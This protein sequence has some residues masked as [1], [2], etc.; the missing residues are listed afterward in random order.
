MRYYGRGWRSLGEMVGFAVV[1]IRYQVCFY[2]MRGRWDGN[3]T[4]R[5]KSLVFK[6]GKIVELKSVF[7]MVKV[8]SIACFLLEAASSE[9]LFMVETRLA[10]S[11][12]QCLNSSKRRSGSVGDL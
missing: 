1:N 9:Y 8:G 12:P 4:L 3:T 5:I 7:V 2:S 6:S 11:L 10:A